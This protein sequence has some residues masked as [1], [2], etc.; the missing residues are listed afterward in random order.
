MIVTS[1]N[2][3]EAA[4]Y[5]NHEFGFLSDDE[6]IVGECRSYFEALWERAEPDLPRSA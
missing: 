4:L 6:T 2:L 1:A 5:R 3:T